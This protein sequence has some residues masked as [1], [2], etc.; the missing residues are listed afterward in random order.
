MDSPVH[1]RKR[2]NFE[3]CLYLI[4]CLKMGYLLPG[5]RTIPDQI[6]DNKDP[7][8][9]ALESADNAW[10]KGMIDLTAMKQ[11][12]SCMLAEQLVAVHADSSAGDE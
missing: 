8:Y 6:S 12:L 7:Y 9:K 10:A 3:G 5:K 1:G 4:L 11:L 2:E